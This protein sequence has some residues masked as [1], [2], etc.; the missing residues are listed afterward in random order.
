MSVTDS[1]RGPWR[2]S[3][4]SVNGNCVEVR[5]DGGTCSVR[6]SESADGLGITCSETQ[7][8]SFCDRLKAAYPAG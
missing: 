8:R 1:R 2:K 6:D 7:W 5:F 3:S 4:Y